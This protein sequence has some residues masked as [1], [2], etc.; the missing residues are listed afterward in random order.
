V[1]IQD[2]FKESGQTNISQEFNDSTFHNS[3]MIMM[4]TDKKMM[5]EVLK[6]LKQENSYCHYRSTQPICSVKRAWK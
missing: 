1:E 6:V 4:V 2:L 5:G 3:I